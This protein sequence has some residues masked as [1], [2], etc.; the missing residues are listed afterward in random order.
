MRDWR[1]LCPDRPRRRSI[2]EVVA[3]LREEAGPLAEPLA[4]GLAVIERAIEQHFPDNIFCDLDFLAASL[5]RQARRAPSMRAH[6]EDR[7]AR[8]VRLH[9]LYGGGTS[10]RFRYV[11]DF[12]YGYDWAKWV[13]RDPASRAHAG[14]FDLELLEHVERRGQELLGLIDQDDPTYHRLRDSRHRNPFGF[15]R[16]PDEEARLHEDLARRGWIPVEAW[17][18][19]ASPVWDRPYAEERERRALELALER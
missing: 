19:Y 6:I 17:R 10:I 16:D 5:V 9:A 4:A 18:L 3:A 2:E 12:L 13:R 1:S 8:V 14:P 11:H 7:V 15:G